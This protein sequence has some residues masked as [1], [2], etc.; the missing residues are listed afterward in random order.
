MKNEI[1]A[2][3]V[4]EVLEEVSNTRGPWSP[5]SCSYTWTAVGR[6]FKDSF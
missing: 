5:K 2:I 1:E 4:E 6:Y 3:V